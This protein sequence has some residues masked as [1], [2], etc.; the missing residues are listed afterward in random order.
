MQFFFQPADIVDQVLN[1]GQPAPIDIRVSGPNSDETYALAAKLAHDLRSVPGVVDSHV[2][3]VPDAPALAVNIDRTL[4]TEFG[5]NQQNT[6][7]NVLVTTNSS[8]QT[9][10]NFW[11]DPRNNVSY[12]LVVQMPTYRINSTQDLWTMPVTVGQSN[13]ARPTFDECRQIRPRHGADGLVAIQYQAGFRCQCR[14]AG[15]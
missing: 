14:C 5:M 13:N 4:A 12:P 1:F 10:P 8:A 15:T 11:V 6:A 7:S 9:A 3:Q 2:F